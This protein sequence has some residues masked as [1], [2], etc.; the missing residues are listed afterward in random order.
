MQY[1]HHDAIARNP[2][3]PANL[4]RLV[5]QMAVEDGAL[6][7]ALR[8]EPE[9]GTPARGGLLATVARRMD[10]GWSL[11]GTKIYCTGAPGLTWLQVWART[12]EAIPRVGS[13]LVLA[14]MPGIRV[15]ETWDHLGLRA[16]GSH[17]VIFDD[18]VIPQDHA[19]DIRLPAEWRGRDAH[20]AAWNVTLI[21]AV[22]TGVAEAAQD[23]L[24]SFLT[25][26]VPSNLG[27]PL[28]SLTRM[29]EAMGRIE[30]RLLVN[31]HLLGGLARSVATGDFPT[32]AEIDLL[33]VSMAENAIEATRD[34]V[35]L[36]GNHALSR[37]NPLERHFRD[38]LCAH[39]H[40]PQTDSALI[41]AGRARLGV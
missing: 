23:W 19:V 3:W 25:S 38:V 12:D 40:T 18:V 32:V 21:S 7:N 26:R 35:G 9:L 6:I 2:H 1:L 34:A 30:A 36:C 22:Y 10:T 16:S 31:R 41:T 14:N 39:I 27:A 29:Q 24:R 4:A 8:V 15:V 33:K 37:A 28:A 20:Q 17:T 11:S 5:G 13:F